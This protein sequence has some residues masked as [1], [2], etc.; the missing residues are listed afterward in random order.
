[1][2][3]AGGL[4]MAPLGVTRSLGLA[5]VISGVI[6]GLAAVANVS[7]ITLI[8]AKAP[9]H[10]LGRLSSVLM[11]SSVSLTPAS[12]A[13]SG[14]VARAIGVGGLFLAG[15]ALLVAV[16]VVALVSPAI[17]GERTAGPISE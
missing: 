3:A 13:I 8:Q 14:G 9:P 7:I 12:Y 4:L 11:F 6:G 15:A 10:L 5:V 17:R 2:A 16:A 1:M